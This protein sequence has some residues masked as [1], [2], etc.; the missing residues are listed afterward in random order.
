M[1]NYNYVRGTV[2]PA[3]QGRR[4]ENKCGKAEEKIFSARLINIHEGVVNRYQKS[5][6][7][8]L[9]F[10]TNL[11]THH[12]PTRQNF[13]TNVFEKMLL[14]SQTSYLGSSRTLAE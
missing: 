4:K 8:K 5:K 7:C 10:I 12:S 1:F 6:N 11:T 9:T 2:E 14:S 13:Q 3:S